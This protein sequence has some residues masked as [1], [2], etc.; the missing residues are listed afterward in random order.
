MNQGTENLNLDNNRE[1][2]S[3]REREILR[4][5]ATGASNKDI[6]QKLSIS[7]NTVKVHLRNIF[8]KIQVNS[9]TEAAMYA[10]NIGLVAGVSGDMRQD[11]NVVDTLIAP[12]VVLEQ[13]AEQEILAS[14]L[15]VVE[16]VA[17]NRVAWWIIGLVVFILGGASVL[18]FYLS[19]QPATVLS[20]TAV[21]TAASTVRWRVLSP[22]P[23]ARQDLATAISADR[24]YAI[25]GKTKEGVT[26]AVERY[27]S[28]ADAWTPVASKPTPVYEISAVSVGG[29]IFVPGGRLN[30]EAVSDV[31]EI[32]D[33]RL[34]TWT[35][36]ATLPAALSAYALATYEGRIYLFGGWD[37]SKYVA[38]L[39]IYDPKQD[40]W[41]IGSP[42]P[43]AR[44]Y[45]GTAV[46]NDKIFLVGG[47]DGQH[48]LAIS[49][50]FLPALADRP[51]EAWVVGEPLPEARYAMG[52][53]NVAGSVYVI[54]GEGDSTMLYPALAYIDQTNE[55]R[56]VETQATQLGSHLSL[57]SVGVNIYA[58]GGVLDNAVSDHNLVYEAFRTISVPLIIK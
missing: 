37:G 16:P 2:L 12:A 10:V 17:Q 6:A 45:L 40:T 4:L 14:P 35:K 25:G 27:D 46:T 38:S 39:Y 44:G 30:S 19:R 34:D 57:A 15:E 32:Y 1:E 5:V 29:R 53:V 49:E 33:P 22:M 55:W 7:I 24:I 8:A 3:E 13:H 51:A 11:A 21:L 56:L 50:I 31:L 52:V 47:F 28:V 41:T 42:M 54:G 26:G 9:R 36:G 23:T 18:L 58:I 20:P 43:T 48:A